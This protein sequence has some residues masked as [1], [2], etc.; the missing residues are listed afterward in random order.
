MTPLTDA[1]N[2]AQ[3]AFEEA[4]PPHHV[5]YFAP[6]LPPGGAGIFYSNKYKSEARLISAWQLACASNRLDTYSLLPDHQIHWRFDFLYDKGGANVFDTWKTIYIVS[7]EL[8]EF[9]QISCQDR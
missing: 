8:T 3:P 9:S 4:A 6:H 1:S 5:Y 2:A 7:G